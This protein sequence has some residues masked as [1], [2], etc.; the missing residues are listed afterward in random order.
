MRSLWSSCSP[1]LSVYLL[2]ILHSC[3]E[4]R[5]LCGKTEIAGLTV[6]F[7]INCLFKVYDDLMS[8]YSFPSSLTL[9]LNSFLS[10][11][12]T[13]QH[14]FCWLK[15]V[16]QTLVSSLPLTPSVMVKTI[17]VIAVMHLKKTSMNTDNFS[18]SKK[19]IG[20][21]EFQV[22][23]IIL[24]SMLY[25]PEYFLTKWPRLFNRREEHNGEKSPWKPEN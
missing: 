13:L 12:L 7:L 18:D 22:I 2:I 16:S 23:Q 4:S 24:F 17:G 14:T 20:T 3:M 21:F 25:F 1:V 19:I 11:G 15:R 10:W 8:L 6:C 9:S 5:G